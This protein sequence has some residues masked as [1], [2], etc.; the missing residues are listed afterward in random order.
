MTRL[1]CATM[2]IGMVL[3][4]VATAV[5]GNKGLSIEIDRSQQIAGNPF[6]VRLRNDGAEDLGYCMSLCGRIISTDD[7]A[8][9]P[10]FEVQILRNDR[11]ADELWICDVGDNVTSAMA[12]SGE[13][14][15]FKIKLTTPGRYRL[16]LSYRPDRLHQEDGACGVGK[17]KRATSGEFEVIEQSK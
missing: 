3:A 11:W 17:W 12:R 9:A 4:A 6:E 14:V 15:R 5:G 16:R 1:L 13:S 10:A 2:F 7:Q 8:V